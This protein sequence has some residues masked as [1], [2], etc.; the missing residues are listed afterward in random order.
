MEYE[1]ERLVEE[2]ER[3][4]SVL[5]KDSESGDKKVMQELLEQKQNHLE[6][7]KQAGDLEETENG[8]PAPTAGTG[9]DSA[10]PAPRQ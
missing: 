1:K 2:I 5:D 3:L 4:K 6:S 9:D 7:L 8:S 10:P